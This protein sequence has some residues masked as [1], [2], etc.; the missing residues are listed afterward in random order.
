MTGPEPITPDQPLS[1][2]DQILNH[3]SSLKTLIKEHNKNTRALI[4]HI[5]LTFGEEA[6]GYKGK[7]KEN[8]GVK[9][10]DDLKKPYNE[11]L[12]SLF[13]RRI[14]EFSALSH[15]MP[16]NLRIYDGSTDPDDHISRFIGA[17]NQGEW[18]MPIWCRMFQQTLDGPTR[19]WFDRMPNGY[20]DSWVNLCE[21][22]VERFALRRRCSK[23]PTEVLKI[24]RRANETLPNFK[25]RWTE[26][27]GYI[28]GVPELARRF[29]D[30]VPHTVTE[31]MKRVDDF[32]N[33]EEAF[34][35]TELPMG[36]QSKKGHEAPYRG[37]RPTRTAQGG[38][39]P[40][41]DVYNSYNMRDHYQSYVPRDNRSRGFLREQLLPMGKIELEVMFGSEGLSRRTTMRFTVIQA[42]SPYNIILGRTGVRKLHAIS[43]TTHAMMKFPTPRGISMLV[44]RRDVIF[45]CRQLESKHVP[46]KEKESLTEDFMI[47]LAF[48]DQKITI[49]T[50]FSSACRLQL[51]NL[52]K[53]NKDVFA[54]QPSDMAGIPGRISQHSLNMNPSIA[55]VPQK[56]RVLG[57]KKARRRNMEDA[58]RFQEPQ[59]SMSRR[60]LPPAG[61]RPGDRSAKRAMLF[62]ETL[63]N[64]TKENR[65]DFHWTEAAEQAFQELKKLIME[66]PM[67]TTLN[68]KEILYVYIA[69]FREAILN[70]PEASGKLAKYAVELGAYNITYIHRNTVKG[71]VLA[72]F[73][74]EVPLG[75]KHLEICSLADDKK[76]GEWTLFID[77]ASSLKG[78]GVGLVLIDPTRTEYTYAIWLNFTRTN[79]EVEYKALLAGLRIAGKMKFSALKVKVD[80]ILVACQLNGEFVASSDGMAKYLAKAKELA[81]SFKSFQSK[82]ASEPKSKGRCTK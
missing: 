19:G 59:L 5:R 20:I 35:S 54:W 14:I 17:A 56:R 74:N 3:V 62:F 75:T 16:E 61:D 63:K 27:M 41:G 33:S 57:L 31:M 38:G 9:V 48:P 22:F 67:L 25:E 80:Y 34:K 18:E 69:A 8:E 71:Q 77:G 42:S 23:D 47:N 15:R 79:N 43:S 24:V 58:H 4:T 7:D 1:L 10:D 26:E 32:V 51:I 55:P 44:P 29:V 52:L 13:T 72:D 36:E 39:P 66:L 12:D 82:R 50:Q 49:K 11:V 21:R 68:P 30:Q 64:I 37:F 46:P 53:D 76:V 60:L 2:Q 6:D 73:L 81:A 45:E 70:K 28:Q 78:A 40:K 65:N